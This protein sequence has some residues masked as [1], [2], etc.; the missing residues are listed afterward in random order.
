MRVSTMGI[1]KSSEANNICD[2][3]GQQK[4]QINAYVCVY[5]SQCEKTVS[6]YSSQLDASS[7]IFSKAEET[8][9][10]VI[11]MR[12]CG[13]EMLRTHTIIVKGGLL[14]LYFFSFSNLAYITIFLSLNYSYIYRNARHMF[15]IYYYL[16]HHI[17]IS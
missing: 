3:L 14:N 1:D 2:R 11:E 7:K 4:W 8:S 12:C 16:Y 15:H 13:I 10:A 5:V 17:F 9:S 6:T